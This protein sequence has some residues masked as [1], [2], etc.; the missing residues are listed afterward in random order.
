M[1]RGDDYVLPQSG[2]GLFEETNC[3]ALDVGGFNVCV[4]GLGLLAHA[5]ETV[6]VVGWWVICGLL[7][8]C[9]WDMN[10]LFFEEGYDRLMWMVEFV[11]GLNLSIRTC[12]APSASQRIHGWS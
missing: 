6:W 5:A 11:V 10:C 7:L 1:I 8:G 4:R 9:Y 3:Y 2:A 12:V